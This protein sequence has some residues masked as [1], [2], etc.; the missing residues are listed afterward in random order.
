MSRKRRKEQNLPPLFIQTEIYTNTLKQAPAS[1]FYRSE[2]KYLIGKKVTLRGRYVSQNTRYVPFQR[3][4]VSNI[5]V[6]HVTVQKA[7]DWFSKR[8]YQP[9]DHMW[10]LAPKDYMNA[11]RIRPDTT[12]DFTGILYEYVHKGKRNISLRLLNAESSYKKER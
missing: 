4:L 9:I 8:K 6:K 2:L 11:L 12:V 1:M 7:P 3:G 10:I 5:L